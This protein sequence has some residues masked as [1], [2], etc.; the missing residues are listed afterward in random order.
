[1]SKSFSKTAV[2]SLKIDGTAGSDQWV[3]YKGTIIKIGASLA[4]YSRTIPRALVW[5]QGGGLLL[6]SEVPL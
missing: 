1:M 6:I 3:H 5:S 2:L 4:P